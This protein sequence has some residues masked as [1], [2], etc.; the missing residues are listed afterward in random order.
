MSLRSYLKKLA[1]RAGNAS[2]AHK[3]AGSHV[4]TKENKRAAVKAQRV[5]YR[6]SL[7]RELDEEQHKAAIDRFFGSHYALDNFD[8]KGTRTGRL[9]RTFYEDHHLDVPDELKGKDD[10]EK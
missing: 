7:L 5:S 1:G 9:D 4:N 10:D 6:A 8:I 2:R 3:A